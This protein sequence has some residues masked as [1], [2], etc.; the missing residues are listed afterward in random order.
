MSNSLESLLQRMGEGSVTQGWGA[1]TVFSRRRINRLL[2]QQYI[3]N[4]R[5]L[6]LMPMVNGRGTIVAAPSVEAQLSDMQ[7]GPPQVSFDNASLSNS[8]ARVRMNIVSGRYTAMRRDYSG[9]PGLV[10]S[11]SITEDQGFWI[12]MVVDLSVVLGEV[13]RQGMVTLDLSKAMDF[14]CNLA[15]NDSATN[16]GLAAIFRQ[17]FHDLPVQ[18]SVF[19]LG[20]LGLK[21]YGVLAPA[22]FRIL[23]QAAP[24]ARIRSALNYGDGAVVVFIRL[25]AND[26]DGA[27]P[28]DET[29]PYLIPDDQESDG[30][31]RYSATVVL[32]E[33]M[34]DYLAD[35]PLDLLGN[36]LFPGANV[37]EERDRHTP[38]DLA[39]F[40]NISPRQTL[41]TLEP[42]FATIKAG[43]N[44]RF[45]LLNGRGEA[46]T[47]SAWQAVSLESH[48][49]AGHGS[50]YG[51][52][53][54]AVARDAIGYELLHV[55][56]TAEYEQDGVNYSA[57]ALLL[58]VFDSMQVSPR[59]GLSA[60]ADEPPAILLAAGALDAGP[61]DWSL[62]GATQGDL[63]VIDGRHA[64]F[65][66]AQR[67]QRKCLT[68]QQVWAQ[69]EEGRP[70]ALLL[71]SGQQLL[72]V[73]P[74]LAVGIRHSTAVQLIADTQILPDVPR[75]WSLI[76]GSGTVSAAG[77]YSAPV[78]AV[79]GSSVVCCE[80]VSNGIV[81]ASGYSVL[82][83]NELEQE[84][85]WKSLNQFSVRVLGGADD[86]MRGNLYANGYQQ[87]EIEILV[88]TALVDGRPIPLSALELNSIQLVENR[89]DQEVD[90]I[91]PLLGGMPESDE[92]SWRTHYQRNRFDMATLGQALSDGGRAP[93]PAVRTVSRYLHSRLG[94]NAS[95]SFYAQLQRSS[96]QS[97]WRSNENDELHGAVT[98]TS[99]ST[100][101]FH[102]DYYKFERK[103]VDGGSAGPGAPEEDDFDYHLR[104]VD[105]WTLSYSPPS[106]STVRFETLEFGAENPEDEINR[107]MVA[108]ES[109]ALWEEM[110]SWTGYIFDD[111]QSA[112]D[113]SAHV[114]FDDDL[115]KL[116][117]GSEESNDERNFPIDVDRSFF[118]PGSLVI[119]LHRS[120]RVAY[121]PASSSEQSVPLS[122][123]RDKLSRP[124]MVVLRDRQGNVHKRRISFDAPANLGHRNRL[125]H[126]EFDRYV[127]SL[128][129]PRS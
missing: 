29:F 49:S 127:D 62:Q 118:Q 28:P 120:D 89:T 83:L 34:R 64:L 63:A 17:K 111:P 124:L 13:D 54:E 94:G 129:V 65:S 80:I 50:I 5:H 74:P 93:N 108:W 16:A 100:P 10:T 121:V 126:V 26:T 38:A 11:L 70:A 18:R 9:P 103:R 115:E 33:S 125:N 51:G 1:I 39:L 107:S 102:P 14:S 79:T 15:G 35:H 78:D 71:A 69:G 104:T 32:A 2:E 97:F 37:F 52:L 88:E 91:N 3:E 87:L 45:T 122:P 110:F 123:V 84:E 95:V 96:D 40:G 36:L 77:L 23:T 41:Y 42:R 56:V 98:I 112:A 20:R 7:L 44:Q 66:P 22:G 75:R 85:S 58:V 25:R 27:F 101:A 31:D 106:M 53:Y 113:D 57:S 82:E 68:A 81:L 6:G 30:S 24:G 99:Q 73:D 12:E 117:K 90:S 116:V 55:V 76:A 114:Q 67:P 61:L 47:A 21:A 48:A 105:Y 8:R 4:F 60:L 128:G 19:Q 43:A 92:L 59:V 119:T 86:G 46:V 72:G 109:E